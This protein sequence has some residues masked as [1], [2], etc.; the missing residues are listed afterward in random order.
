MWVVDW[1]S[2]RPEGLHILMQRVGEE[3]GARSLNVARGEAV[4][5][6]YGPARSPYVPDEQAF[7]VPHSGEDITIVETR[8]GRRIARRLKAMT[9][10]PTCLACHDAQPGEILG[11]LDVSCDLARVQPTGPDF[12]RNLLLVSLLVSV[13][14][15][16]LVFLV[17]SRVNMARRIESVTSLARRAD[18]AGI[19][20]YLVKPVTAEDLRPALLLARAG[21]EEFEVLRQAVADL[22][23]ALETR[24]LV[25]RAKG[26]LMRRLDIGEEE[27]FRRLQKRSQ[28]ENRRMR[29]VAKAIITADEM[30]AG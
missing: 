17:F 21:F 27:A 1:E 4:T 26:I 22:R 13:I 28:D 9:A 25:E 16:L 15:V 29:E 2:E 24:K 8:D 23:Q 12:F 5:R 10:T 20:A 19:F 3:N 6:Q 7:E 11:V 18:D 14:I 30:F